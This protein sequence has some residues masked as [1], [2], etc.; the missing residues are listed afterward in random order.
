MPTTSFTIRVPT[1]IRQGKELS[2]AEARVHIDLAPLL[3]Q[4]AKTQG[5]KPIT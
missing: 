2:A 4:A 1:P 3:V 5:K